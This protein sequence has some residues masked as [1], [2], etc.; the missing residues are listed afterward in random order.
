METSRKNFKLTLVC[1]LIIVVGVVLFEAV[2]KLISYSLCQEFGA[3]YLLPGEFLKLYADYNFGIANMNVSPIVLMIILAVVALLFL[4]LGSKADFKK[5]PLLSTSLFL[6][7]GALI[8]NFIDRVAT[9]GYE[10]TYISV[11]FGDSSI[12]SFNFSHIFFVLG[13]VLLI[14]SAFICKKEVK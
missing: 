13:A 10:L 5:E 12:P 8:S 9:N 6:M 14:V 7:S 2:F 3:Y 1:G 4:F 11:T